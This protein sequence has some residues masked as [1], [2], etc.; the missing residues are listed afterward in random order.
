MTHDVTRQSVGIEVRGGMFVPLIPRGT[1][2]PARHSEIF[3]TADDGQES[4][5]VK[6]F[7]GD[8]ESTSLNHPVGAYRVLLPHRQPRG[9]PQIE[10]IFSVDQMHQVTV[11]ARDVHSGASVSVVRD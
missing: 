4:I 8:Y 6:V 2:V 11:T 9:V 10:V 3:T 1:P 7:A 5:T